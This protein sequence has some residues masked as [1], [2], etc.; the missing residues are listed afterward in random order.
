MVDGIVALAVVVV[1]GGAVLVSRMDRDAFDRA[2]PS[3]A[4][5]V[6]VPGA[7][8]PAE[9]GDVRLRLPPTW[10]WADLYGSAHASGRQMAPD[11]PALADQLNAR[12]LS[13]PQSALLAGF[14]GDDLQSPEYSTNLVVM[15]QLDSVPQDAEGLREL[16]RAHLKVEDLPVSEVSYLETS[17]EPS[18]R[19]RYRDTIEGVAVETLLYWYTTA[20]GTFALSVT[21]HHLDDYVATAD[22][23][24]A[25]FD[26]APN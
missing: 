10:L 11:D 5:T 6:P 16:V 22:S 7:Y 21:S 1:L 2:S 23:I 26:I 4:V 9:A 24:A 17:G 12:M 18:L 25:T 8:E 20:A 3:D 14:D 19:V 15:P 13:L